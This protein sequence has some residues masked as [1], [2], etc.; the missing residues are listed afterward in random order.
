MKIVVKELV[1]VNHIY[2]FDET[3]RPLLIDVVSKRKTK[4]HIKKLMK[5]HHITGLQFVSVIDFN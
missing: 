4:G 2:I 5:T 3:M 1:E